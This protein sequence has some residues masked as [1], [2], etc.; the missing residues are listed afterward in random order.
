MDQGAPP[1][2]KGPA[3]G[4]ARAPSSPGQRAERDIDTRETNSHRATSWR[5]IAGRLVVLAV[6]C[7]ASAA[8]QQSASGGGLTTPG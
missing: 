7:Q 8:T 6:G 4:G 3:A 1:A 5:L 2:R